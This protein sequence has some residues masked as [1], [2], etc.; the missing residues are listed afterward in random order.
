MMTV[1]FRR[2]WQI[3]LIV[4]MLMLVVGIA[5]D[6]PDVERYARSMQRL[7]EKGHY[8][9]A[10]EVGKKS[11][12][13]DNALLCLRIE[14]MGHEQL[15]GERLFAYPVKGKSGQMIVYG[16]KLKDLGGDYELCAYLID[17]EL[18]KFVRKLPNYYDVN[19]SLP[20]YY[21]EALVLYKHLRSNPV[22]AYNDEVLDTDYHD[23][24]EL[25][26]EYPNQSARQVAVFRQYEGTYWYYYEYLN[27]YSSQLL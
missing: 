20:R 27:R 11:D 16:R 3:S 14:T 7:I 5:T 19:D 17:K 25:E 6:I 9:E 10:L 13:T 23:L 26:K 22:I 2:V 18:D 21:R 8:R 1:N 4:A 24:Q 12:K 15:L